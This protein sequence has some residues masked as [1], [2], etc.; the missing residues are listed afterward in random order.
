MASFPPQM[1]YLQPERKRGY[2]AEPIRGLCPNLF[3]KQTVP[4]KPTA[5]LSRSPSMR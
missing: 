5:G 3:R 1:L 2:L 4:S